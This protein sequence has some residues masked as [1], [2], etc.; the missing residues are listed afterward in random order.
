MHR[1]IYNIV[2]KYAKYEIEFLDNPEV[3]KIEK[4]GKL[5]PNQEEF[6]RAFL[7]LSSLEKTKKI[8]SDFNYNEVFFVKT[9]IAIGAIF[10]ALFVYDYNSPLSFGHHYYIDNNF[11]VYISRIQIPN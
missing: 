11:N 6:Y 7:V 4:V 1:F 9:R 8:M 5:N 3:F 10:D 2:K